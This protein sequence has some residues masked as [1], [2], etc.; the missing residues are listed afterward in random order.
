MILLP[1][2]CIEKLLE[3]VKPEGVLSLSFFN[4]DAKVFNNLLYG[5]FNYVKDGMPSK[6][7][8]RLNPHNAQQPQRVIDKLES[9]SGVKILTTAGIRC[10]HDYMFD[11]Q[12]I[13]DNYHKLFEM[14]C[15]YGAQAPYKWVGKYFYIQIQK[16]VK[17]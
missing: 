6:N 16:S 7:T 3:L 2:H 11:K 5:N 15:E 13:A 9:M 14:E 17:N 1:F 8:V 12:H 10:I 4:Y